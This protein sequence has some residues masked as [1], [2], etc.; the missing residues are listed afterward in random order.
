MHRCWLLGLFRNFALEASHRAYKRLVHSVQKQSDGAVVVDQ[1]V[2]IGKP[3]LADKQIAWAG[4]HAP[5]RGGLWEMPE[6]AH[7][8]LALSVTPLAAS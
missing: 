5:I 8:A 1:L 6:F 7:C 4:A 2:G 3:V